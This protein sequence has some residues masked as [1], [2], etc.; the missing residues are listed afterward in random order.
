MWSYV[1][2][3]QS[4]LF[5][6]MKSKIGL[7]NQQLR[8]DVWCRALSFTPLV[9]AQKQQEECLTLLTSL[10][11]PR[12]PPAT[13]RTFFHHALHTAIYFPQCWSRGTSVYVHY[14]GLSRPLGGWI[15][16]QRYTDIVV[17]THYT[18]HYP[19]CR[20]RTGPLGPL[21]PLAL[22]FL[23]LAQLQSLL[24]VMSMKLKLWV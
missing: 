9:M 22:P 24:S 2:V 19:R 13:P 5:S 17:I 14:D 10:Y 21:L 23:R 7:G 6:I 20:N 16:S 3:K 12:P 18:H 15:T 11:A 1:S 4:S 8:R